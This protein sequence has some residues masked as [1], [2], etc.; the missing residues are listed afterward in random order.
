M[1]S[2][3]GHSTGRTSPR[4]RTGGGSTTWVAIQKLLLLYGLAN[5]VYH[6]G[7]LLY[8]PREIHLRK[9]LITQQIIYTGGAVYS[10]SI[11]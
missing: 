9:R 8:G 3:V 4:D 1:E 7:L 5:Q 11:M 6:R 10:F 2:L